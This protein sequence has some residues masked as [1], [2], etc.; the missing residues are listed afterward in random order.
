MTLTASYRDV[1][2]YTRIHPIPSIMI[3]KFEQLDH[4]I[5][6]TDINTYTTLTKDDH[7]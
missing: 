6:I 2:T 7:C 4:A 5:W 1:N 3:N